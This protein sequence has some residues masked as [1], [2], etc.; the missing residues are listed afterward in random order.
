[1]CAKNNKALSER[2]RPGLFRVIHNAI[3]FVRAFK[4]SFKPNRRPLILW[5]I[6]GPLNPFR[7]NGLADDE[8]FAPYSSS[9]NN[10]LFNV[11][12]HPVWGRELLDRGVDFVWASAWEDEANG[13]GFALGLEEEIPHITLDAGEGATWK[14]DSVDEWLSLH[15][16]GRPV[17]W[18]D[19]ELGPDAHAWAAERGKTLLITVDAAHGWSRSQFETMIQWL[20]EISA[21]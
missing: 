19:D 3:N 10:G 17:I 7:A 4:N 20:D 11:V 16:P 14:L 21:K 2:Q 18:I 13:A 8:R 9:W 15:A 6:D 5:D 12:E 1:M